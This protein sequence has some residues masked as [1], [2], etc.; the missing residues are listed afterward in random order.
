MRSAITMPTAYVGLAATVS[1]AISCLPL[2]RSLIEFA[3]AVHAVERGHFVTLRQ[4]RV[5]E[6]R[7][8]EIFQLAT[9]RHHRLADVQQL[10]RSFA[11]DMHAQN[12]MR[13]AMKNDI[14]PP[15]SIP[16]NLHTRNLAVVRY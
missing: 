11:D 16:A 5:V 2:R 8:H 4:R 13:L 6:H 9:E 14:Q 15:R 7:L 10:A 3:D 12:R 1:S